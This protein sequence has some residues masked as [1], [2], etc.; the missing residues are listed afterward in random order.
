V[1]PFEA[2]SL[3]VK[4]VPV[5]LLVPVDDIDVQGLKMQKKSQN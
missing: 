5:V 2:H 4:Q 3:D 1:P